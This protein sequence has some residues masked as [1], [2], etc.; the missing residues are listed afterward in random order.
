MTTTYK[1]ICLG[2]KVFRVFKAFKDLK[3]DLLFNQI[4]R[5]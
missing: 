1:G 4:K 5:Y 3:P 2:L